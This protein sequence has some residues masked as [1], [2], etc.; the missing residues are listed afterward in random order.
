M[1]III[2]PACFVNADIVQPFFSE[3]GGKQIKILL[4]STKHSEKSFLLFLTK[5]AANSQP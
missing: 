5:Q 3:N 4:L 1:C 2:N